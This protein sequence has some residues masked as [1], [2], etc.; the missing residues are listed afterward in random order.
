MSGL[1]LFRSLFWKI[2][3]SPP[4]PWRSRITPISPET[5]ELTALTEVTL[6]VMGVVSNGEFCRRVLTNV[7][8]H[9][10]M[11]FYA[12]ILAQMLLFILDI[13]CCTSTTSPQ[14]SRYTGKFFFHSRHMRSERRNSLYMRIN[15]SRLQSVSWI[16]F[17]KKKLLSFSQGSINE[18]AVFPVC[19]LTLHSICWESPVSL[20]RKNEA[21]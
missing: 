6:S 1:L 15:T 5:S 4:I 13:P 17:V 21:S 14:T 20:Y 10:C 2:S 12:G 11:P 7:F 16:E 9:Q 18:Y 19:I 8:A 3:D